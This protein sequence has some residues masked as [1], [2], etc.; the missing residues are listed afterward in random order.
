MA[1]I[2]DPEKGRFMTTDNGAGAGR[3]PDPGSEGP[4]PSRRAMLRGAAGAGMAAAAVAAG[5]S[6]ALAASRSRASDQASDATAV[7]DAAPD[8]DG[9]AIVAHLR[10]ASSGEIDVFHGTRQVRLHDRDLAARL[11]RASR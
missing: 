7:A 2:A 8:H 3:T 11:I 1:V 9:E 6:P 4:Q 5:A 10:D